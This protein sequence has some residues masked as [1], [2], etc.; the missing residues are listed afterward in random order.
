MENIS[1]VVKAQVLNDALPYIQKYH[2]KIVVIK[3]G[4]NAMT[5]EVPLPLTL[6]TV[7]EVFLKL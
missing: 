4:G 6:F 3:Y 1:N 7:T 2:D 5:S